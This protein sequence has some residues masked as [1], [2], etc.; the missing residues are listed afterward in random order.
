MLLTPV[1]AIN[2]LILYPLITYAAFAGI[3]IH[4][5]CAMTNHIHLVVTDTQGLLP[6]FLQCFHRAVSLCLKEHTGLR[7]PLWDHR[8][9]SVVRLLTPEAVL[10][11]IA[12]VLAN[13]VRAKLVQHAHEWTGAKSCVDDIGQGVLRAERPN[14][15]FSSKNKR[16]QKEAAIRVSLPPMF[17]A[18]DAEMVR[19]QIAAMIERY[20][21]GLTREQVLG[22]EKA[23][24]VS[25]EEQAKTQRPERDRNPTF[26]VGHGDHRDE[27]RKRAVDYV[28]AFQNSYRAARKAWCDGDRDVEFPAGTWAMKQYHNAKV[29]AVAPVF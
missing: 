28:R 4:A 13:P 24:Q 5:F 11:E 12:Y 14:V 10:E 7:G 16:W 2:N 27:M 3:Q 9:P 23:Q 8:P 18:E 20:E 25:P 29:S 22:A 26:A 15:F 21:A 19:G 1:E 17:K 6:A